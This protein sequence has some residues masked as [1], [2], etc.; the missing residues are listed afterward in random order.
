MLRV[1]TVLLHRMLSANAMS[2][3]SLNPLKTLFHQGI[4]QMSLLNF[5]S[6]RVFIPSVFTGSILTLKKIV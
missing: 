3:A 6:V 5:M 2:V 1:F 4:R